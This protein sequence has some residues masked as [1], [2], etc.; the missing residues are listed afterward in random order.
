MSSNNSN[1][2]PKTVYVQ[3]I[4]YDTNEEELAAAF[5][6]FGK[7]SSCKIL[8][9]RLYGQLF[10]RGKGFIEFE[11][12]ESAEKAIKNDKTITV[13]GRSLSVEHAYKKYERK[14][15]TAFVSGI[16]RKT[17]NEDLI[18]EFKD[19]NATDALIVYEDA[20]GLRGGYAFIKFASTE[21]RNKAVEEK[22]KFTLLGK[23][24]K[25]SIARRDFDEAN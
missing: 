15:D 7:V 16:P 17:T 22:K 6:Q 11:Q 10:S 3:N 24:S 14:N 19:Y 2:D 23:E 13:D 4:N 1:I 5:E 18:N 8:K 9:D 20:Y 25:L 12:S 21:S